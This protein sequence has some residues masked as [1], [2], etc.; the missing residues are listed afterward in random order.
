MLLLHIQQY[1]PTTIL[2]IA[3][4]SRVRAE[5]ARLA[6]RHDR[7][8][9]GS[10]TRLDQIASCSLG[11]LIPQHDVVVGSAP[12]VAMTLDFHHGSRMVLQ[13]L[14]VAVQCL[15]SGI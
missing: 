2:L 11:T 6:V 7:H 10:Y 5:R 8:L 4:F 13:P 3:G 9:F 12:F 14:C 1:V 15:H